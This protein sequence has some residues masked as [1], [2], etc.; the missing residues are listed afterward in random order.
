M[1]CKSST[2]YSVSY[3]PTI[4]EYH[5][6]KKEFINRFTEWFVEPT[7]YILTTENGKQNYQNHL[8]GFVQFKEE[9]LAS[10]F[11]RSFHTRVMKEIEV[12]D[13]KI[14]LKIVPITRDVKL[15]KGYA[16]KEKKLGQFDAV[17]S[18]FDEKELLE[19]QS[20]YLEHQENKAMKGDKVS[21]NNRNLF[22][23][24]E[25][26]H[27][28]KYGPKKPLIDIGRDEIIKGLTEMA[29]EGYWI[30]NIFN[31]RDITN[32]INKLWYYMNR[33]LDEYII[34]LDRDGQDVESDILDKARQIR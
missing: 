22:K 14:A 11:R 28:L 20:Y 27:N 18:N 13:L 21:V 33:K 10:N 15:C 3:H 30:A 23:V 19:Y 6:S 31:R 32:I 1:P 17:I 16:L 29:Y 34:S 5:N 2:A 4:E 7:K 9:K 24:Y 26:F 25:K 8:Q 12:N